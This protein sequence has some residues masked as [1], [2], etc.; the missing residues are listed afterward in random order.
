M[1]S[2]QL[3]KKWQDPAYRE[4]MR[5]AHLGQKAWNKGLKMSR[6]HRAKLSKAH[7]G[8]F[9]GEKHPNWKGDKVGYGGIHTWVRK[10]YGKANKCQADLIGLICL[11]ES[12][13]FDWAK[14][15]GKNYERKR[16][17][18]VM[19]CHKCHRCYD[20]PGISI[21]I[22]C[23]QQ[24]EF[25]VDALD[26]VIGQE[27]NRYKGF[28]I[29]CVID[30][31]TDGSL[32]VAKDYESK[33]VKVIYQ[34]NRGLSSARNSGIMWANKEFVLLLDCDD[35][36]LPNAVSKLLELIEQNSDADIIAPSFKTF[37]TT[38]EEV[39]LMPNPTIE[40]FKQGNRVGYCQAIRRSALLAV[41][42][43][44]PKMVEGYEDL[45]LIIN[46]LS[47]GYKIQTIPEVLW[48]YRTKKESMYTKITPEIHKKLIGQINKDFPEARL[49]F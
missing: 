15:R 16:E 37:G 12:E 7:I 32:E 48:M 17:N 47:R 20:F 23:F 27:W 43:Y 5:Q 22:P 44:N 29:I 8:Q 35:I 33:G 40:D 21:I 24:V 45:H 30:G 13:N 49:E 18:F 34:T 42:G 9:L 6:K 14:L 36:L 26:S 25:L 41:G 1:K 11:G 2:E 19:L 10:I 3:K 28:E 4:H 39:I 38:N 31:A 46:L